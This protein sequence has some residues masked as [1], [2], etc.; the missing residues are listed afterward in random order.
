MTLNLN[1]WLK[2]FGLAI[3]TYGFFACH[4][5]ISTWVGKL[6]THDRAQAAS[7]YLFSYYIGGGIGGTIGGTFYHQ[8]DW[9]GVVGMITVLSIISILVSIRLGTVTKEKIELSSHHV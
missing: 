1:I 8:F 7:L 5:I 9:L 6:A 4:S 3:F 2:I